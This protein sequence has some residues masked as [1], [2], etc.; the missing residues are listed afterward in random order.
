MFE[1]SKILPLMLD[2]REIISFPAESV[3]GGMTTTVS[4]NLTINSLLMSLMSW[5]NIIGEIDKNKT[6]VIPDNN[7][8]ILNIVFLLG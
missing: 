8:I 1:L 2:F 3:P 7:I 4:L 6:R 5:E